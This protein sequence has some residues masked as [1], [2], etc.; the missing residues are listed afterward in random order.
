VYEIR[1]ATNHI[2]NRLLLRVR[3]PEDIPQIIQYFTINKAYLTPFSPTW[4]DGFFTAEYWQYQIEQYHL[5]LI[6]GCALRLFIYH[7]INR[8]KIIGVVNFSSF[9]RGAANFCNVGYSLAETAQSHGY[10][11]EPLQA[12]TEYIFQELNFHRIM[13]NYMPHNRRSGNMLK[14]KIGFVI[15]GY[16]R[17]YILINSKWE[18]HIFTSL[19]NYNWKP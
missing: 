19:T 14:K 12:S 6:H 9:V 2:T 13:A 11:T 17:D 18:D 15:E 3:I 16:A 4:G 10:M 8:T 7:Q 1:T 5:E